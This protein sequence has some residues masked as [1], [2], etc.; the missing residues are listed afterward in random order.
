ML[1]RLLFALA[2]VPVFAHAQGNAITFETLS[3]PGTDTF[4]VN[5]LHHIQDD[6]FT[7]GSVH[8]PYFYDTTYGGYWT[9]GFAYS[10]KKDS[11]TSGYTNMYAAKAGT[12]YGGSDKY[13][14]FTP[15][16]VS[17]PNLYIP[18]NPNDT[19]E[20]TNWFLGG[21]MYVTNSTYA[22][23]SMRDGDGLA[24]KFGGVSG[25]DTD[26]FKLTIT[27]YRHRGAQVTRGGTIDFYLADFRFANNAQDYIIKNWTPVNLAPIGGADS[28]DFQLSS[29]DTN[30]YGMLTPAYFCLDNITL[31]VPTAIKSIPAQSL[32]KVYPNP[33]TNHLFVEISDASIRQAAIYDVTGKLITAQSAATGKLNFDIAAFSNGIYFLKLDGNDGSASVRFIKQ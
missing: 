33:A 2:F 12:G 1:K 16:Y 6:G 25:N 17:S 11:V 32:A 8:F 29:S 4:Y 21:T 15:G 23:N 19:V 14:V 27:G 28:L 3:L 31:N 24:K 20:N 10:N 5:S 30:Q 9:G 7:L 13:A 22:Y 18:Q 26:W